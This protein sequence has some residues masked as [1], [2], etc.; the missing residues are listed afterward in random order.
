MAGQFM[1]ATTRNQAPVFR[2][3]PITRLA[4]CPPKPKLFDIT[5][6]TFASRA[7]LGT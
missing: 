5:W 2:Y 4:L 3:R 7:A 1:R 6:S